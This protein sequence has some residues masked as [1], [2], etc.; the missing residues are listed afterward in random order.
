M[1]TFFNTYVIVQIVRPLISF[2]Q[3]YKVFC[4]YI[5][6]IILYYTLKGLNDDVKSSND[7]PCFQTSYIYEQ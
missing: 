3:P 5:R 1:Y 2:I 4:D 6:D 7:T